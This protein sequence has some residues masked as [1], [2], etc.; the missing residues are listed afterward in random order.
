MPLKIM[1]LEI[2]ILIKDTK[3][4]ALDHYLKNINYRVIYYRDASSIL[5]TR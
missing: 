3:R 1:K 4:A 5:K 2:S